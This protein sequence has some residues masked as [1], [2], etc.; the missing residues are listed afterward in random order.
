[1]NPKDLKKKAF[2]MVFLFALMANVDYCKKELTNSKCLEEGW[3]VQVGRDCN[4]AEY[5]GNVIVG[6]NPIIVVD[7][8]PSLNCVKGASHD[9][10]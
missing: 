1:M 8:L 7:Y 5:E 10:L 2:V 3:C 4:P 9:Q 6:C